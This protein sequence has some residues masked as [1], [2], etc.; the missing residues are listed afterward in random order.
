MVGR[1]ERWL[2]TR[3]PGAALQPR[4][5]RPRLP[6]W[7][8]ERGVPEP[9]ADVAAELDAA[10]DCGAQAV[11]RLRPG[12]DRVPAAWQP[13][14][15]RLR[16]QGRVADRALRREPLAVRAARGARPLTLQGRR[17]RRA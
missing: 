14:G 4:H 15:A 12:R 16:A 1:Q 5:S 10:P 17:S 11:P 2:L 8:V 3:R 9:R 13:E 7:G 6:L